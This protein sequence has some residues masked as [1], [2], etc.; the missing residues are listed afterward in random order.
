ASFGKKIFG[1]VSVDVINRSKIPVL[2]IPP[3][4]KWSDPKNI[5]LAL[6]ENEGAETLKDVSDLIQLFKSAV[7]AVIF[8]EEE[9]EA[10][11]VLTHSR[12]ISFI[13]A[14]LQKILKNK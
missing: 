13:K 5:L 9:A 3:T 10:F 11:E 12:S 8:S 7:H 6:E 2:T 1:S 14:S 4:W